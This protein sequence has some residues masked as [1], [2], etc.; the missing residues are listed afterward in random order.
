MS[1][2]SYAD[3]VRPGERR[4]WWARRHPTAGPEP[5]QGADGA[6][7]GIRP[8]TA[9]DLGACARLL[10]VV[11]DEAGYPVLWPDAPRAWL[12]DG[13]SGAWVAEHLGEVLG[14]VA[15]RSVGSDAQSRLRWQEITGLEPSRLAAVSRLFV[16][17]RVR[18]EGIGRAL[19]SAATA[20]IRQRGALPVADVVSRSTQALAL[21]DQQGWRLLA[22]DQWGPADDRLEVHRLVLPATTGDAH[23]FR[24]T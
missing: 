19:L 1:A 10:R 5:R 2:D 3:A 11:H 17:P 23:R 20:A 24:A 14:H 21:F 9:K 15:V 13:V 8:R 12:D 18:G 16:R 22:M 6:V 7:K 4:R